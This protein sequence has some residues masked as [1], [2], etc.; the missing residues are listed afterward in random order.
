MTE[1]GIVGPGPVRAVGPAGTVAALGSVG[2]RFDWW[3]GAEDRWHVASTEAAVRQRLDADG[4][5]VETRLRI[6]GGDAL[7]R[8]TAVPS[9][10]QAVAV[11]EV[12]NASPVPV[13]LAL[14]VTLGSGSGSDEVSVG[15]ET[16]TMGGVPVLRLG[17][18]IARALAGSDPEAM[19]AGLERGDAVPPAELAP[20]AASVVAAIVPLPHTA[21][22]RCVVGP[23]PPGSSLPAPAR[24][25]PAGA[26]AR[27][28][29]AHLDDAASLV[30]PDE[31]LLVALGAARRHLLAG[32]GLA[33]DDAYWQLDVE[34]WVAPVAA[35][36]LDAWGH[37]DAAL[38][39]LLAATGPD[40]PA[41]LARRG[42]DEA[43][44]LLWAWA[45]RLERKPDPQLTEALAPWVEQVTI[46]LLPRPRTRRRADPVGGTWR[47]LGL[48]SGAALLAHAG[49]PLAADVTD[50]VDAVPLVQ[51]SSRGRGGL[52]PHPEGSDPG[53]ALALGARRLGRSEP[54]LGGWLAAAVGANGGE[55][56]PSAARAAPTGALAR[57]GRTQHPLLS[58]V[59]LLAAREA[60]LSESAGPGGPVAILAHPDRSWLGAPLEGHRLPVAGGTV[61]F[62]VRW[63]GTRP[64]LL[65]ET[66]G[67]PAATEVCAP[68][69]DPAWR[70]A[71]PSG[72]ALLAETPGLAEL[73]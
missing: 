10:N 8:V 34:P 43:A 33:L 60:V 55:L 18:P 58:A 23:G 13:A 54:S 41:A 50:A 15:D 49:D 70:D 5:T 65:W 29:R 47:A 31:R 6:P 53:L 27:G 38:E 46:G 37:H 44:S 35:V 25:P 40:D 32:A 7:Q 17:R 57:A 30:V 59:L 51:P 36:A 11:M 72:E 63:H 20:A 48:A 4:V 19:L 22:A 69:L 66:D 16:V 3:V 52:T 42:P 14:V 71:A 28:W 61:S 9:G 24:L 12:E 45:E 62:G 26:V 39:L 2:P 64:A 1:I 21:I 73:S 68:A 56:A 67:R